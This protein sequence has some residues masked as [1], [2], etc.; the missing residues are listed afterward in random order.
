MDVG[1]GLVIVVI[2]GLGV[3]ALLRHQERAKRARSL[4]RVGFALTAVV[5]GLFGLFLI[6]ETLS[7]PGGLK[8][9]GL[10]A[11]WAV[12]LGLLCLL[13]WF[14]PAVAA[15]AL[16]PLV[17]AMTSLSIWFAA[18]SGAWRAFENRHGPIRA[19]LLFA[20]ALALALWGL[21]RTAAAGVML[22]VIGIVPI[23]LS[24]IGHDGMVSLGAVSSA[25]LITGL[26]YLASAAEARRSTPPR[27][28]A[29]ACQ[30]PTA[31]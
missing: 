9:I 31:A 14:R 13:A 24:S 21:R 17:A 22:L 10:V 5:A 2:V 20:L 7:D 19:V 26:C 8:G 3:V 27:P 28:D 4:R 12:P 11:L 15:W 6:G 23:T 30:P 18:D 1:L 25:P 16:V 29:P